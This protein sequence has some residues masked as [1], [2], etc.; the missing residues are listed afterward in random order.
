M[1]SM[2]AALRDRLKA[3]GPV[4]AIVGER[5]YRTVR[6]QGDG[7]PA[8]VITRVSPGRAYTMRGAIRL[9]GSRVRIDAL[10]R[11]AAEVEQLGDVLIASIEPAE[12]VGEIG[13]SRSFL[14]FDR[15]LSEQNQTAFDHRRSLEFIIWWWAI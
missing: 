2:T 11:S 3:A 10:G 7:L 13:F 15:D 14:Q 4:A 9:H 8:V 1:A 12:T 5:V 6:V